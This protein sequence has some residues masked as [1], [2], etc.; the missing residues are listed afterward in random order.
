MLQCDLLIIYDNYYLATPN[1]STGLGEISCTMVMLILGVCI[2]EFT[3]G[4]VNLT[5]VLLSI[6]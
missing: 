3:M 2:F 4:H 5:I 6:S 1:I